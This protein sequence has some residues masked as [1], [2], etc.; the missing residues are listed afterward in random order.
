MR[1]KR[2]NDCQTGGGINAKIYSENH[3][4]EWNR[5][6]V[7]STSLLNYVNTSLQ[8]FIDKE[9]LILEKKVNDLNT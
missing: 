5:S 4:K 9:L 6:N 1:D 7:S 8:R 3:S 2:N